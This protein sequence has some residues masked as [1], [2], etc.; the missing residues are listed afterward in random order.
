MIS[1]L[2]S[3]LVVVL[4]IIAIRRWRHTDIAQLRRSPADEHPL[5]FNVMRH[6]PNNPQFSATRSRQKTGTRSEAG[7]THFS[8]DARVVN[9]DGW[10]LLNATPV[11]ECTCPLHKNIA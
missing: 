2:L 6:R 1:L 8:V 3:L 4:A 11:K 9:P 10:C 7:R 5:E